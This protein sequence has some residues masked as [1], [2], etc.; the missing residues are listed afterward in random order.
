MGAW[1]RRAAQWL[2]RRGIGPV[3]VLGQGGPLA[4]SACTDDAF[5]GDTETSTMGTAATGSTVT[6]TDDA[7]SSGGDA[8]GGTPPGGT[9][10]GPCDEPGQEVPCYSFDAATLDV[11]ACHGGVQICT[12]SGD[13]GD[14][15]TS[16]GSG[17]ATMGE[18]TSTSSGD[19]SSTGGRETSDT[20]Q[21]QSSTTAEGRGTDFGGTSTGRAATSDDGGPQAR[22]SACI[23][24]V[25]PAAET[26]ADQVD[27][28]CDADVDEPDAAGCVWFA[29]NVDADR[30]GFPPGQCLCAPE[31]E[32]NV[33]TSEGAVDCCDLDP[34]TSPEQFEFS[35]EADQCRGWDR[36]CDGAVEL[37]LT[38]CAECILG[39]PGWDC[40][41][42][43][44]PSCGGQGLFAQKFDASCLADSFPAVMRCR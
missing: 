10:V 17:D 26:C 44:I 7:G 18:L 22:W 3:L 25:G 33:R 24:E 38:D 1:S 16:T 5:F 20:G 14:T 4:V 23:G 30:D 15:S 12:V 36:N 6:S 13:K 32:F 2:G 39:S 19:A 11:G 9:R 27:N 29:S 43:A 21:S 31:G 28:D 34:L 35:A 37:E 40:V 8:T 41:A 42:S